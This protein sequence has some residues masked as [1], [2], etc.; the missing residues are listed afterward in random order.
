MSENLALTKVGN[1]RACSLKISDDFPHE[2][3]VGT[4]NYNLDVPARTSFASKEDYNQC[5]FSTPSLGYI[6]QLVRAQKD[7]CE[8]V[9]QRFSW[10]L[11]NDEDIVW[12]RVS[13][14]TIHVGDS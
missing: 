12:Q 7:R 11:V 2:E 5:I 8:F 4:H 1:K 10:I 13:T 9:R 3:F 14:E 6:I